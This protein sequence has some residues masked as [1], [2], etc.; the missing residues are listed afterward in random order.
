LA[1]LRLD[2]SHRGLHGGQVGATGQPVFQPV[3]QPGQSLIV[4]LHA[5]F[6][7]RDLLDRHSRLRL[8]RQS[9]Q[10]EQQEPYH[11]FLRDVVKPSWIKLLAR[12]EG[13]I[14]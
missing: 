12:S 2:R 5:G 7:L 8:A 10:T 3:S 14:T 4:L 6:G 9:K 13:S 11:F 1:K